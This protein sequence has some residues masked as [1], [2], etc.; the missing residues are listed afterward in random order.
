MSP[1]P[2]HLPTRIGL[3]HLDPFSLGSD[4]L[5][6]ESL[7]TVQAPGTQARQSPGCATSSGEG[8]PR[9]DFSHRSF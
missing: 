8:P 5:N 3:I 4:F 6:V 1:Q 9:Q 7:D 2:P